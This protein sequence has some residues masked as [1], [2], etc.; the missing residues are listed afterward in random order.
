[1]GN[2]KSDYILAK[3]DVGG[4]QDYIFATNRLRENAGASYQVTRIMEEFLLESF[5]EA[6]DEETW[7]C[8]WT[9]S[10]QIDCAAADERMM[11]EV[12]YIG[13]GNAVALFQESGFF[14]RVGEKLGIKAAVKMPASI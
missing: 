12:I 1:M 5:R 7:R 6:A 2:I 11:A 13:G 14:C 9:G 3:F 4:I 10:W 8:S